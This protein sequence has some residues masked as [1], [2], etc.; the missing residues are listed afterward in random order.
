MHQTFA[1]FDFDGTLIRGDSIILFMRYLWRRKLCTVFDIARFTVAGGLFTLRLASP[2][3]AKEMALRFLKGRSRAEYMQYAND[4]CETVLKPR[5]F[6]QG[7][8]AIQTHQAAG[9][10]VLIITASPTFYLEPLK[11]ILGLDAVLGTQFATDGQS[12]FTGHIVGI[13]CRGDEKTHPHPGLSD[14]NQ[15]RAGEQKFVRLRQTA[16]TTCPCCA[17]AGTPMP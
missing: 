10:P 12:R 16:R 8:E 17:C 3:R 4:F 7:I 1:L 2:K 6:P 13:N 5:L 14:P 15:L 9:E 11:Q